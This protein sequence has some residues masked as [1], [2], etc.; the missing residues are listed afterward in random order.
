MLAHLKNMFNG[1]L[2]KDKSGQIK[3]PLFKWEDVIIYNQ[4]SQQTKS[5][6]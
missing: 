3:I 6:E 1:V 2:E 4:V 5:V